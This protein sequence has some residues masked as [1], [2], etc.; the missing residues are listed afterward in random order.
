MLTS[1]REAYEQ[2]RSVLETIA[3]KTDSGPCV[4]YVGSDGA[5]HFV[6][7]VR[8]GRARFHKTI[9]SR[10]EKSKRYAPLDLLY[11]HVPE[12]ASHE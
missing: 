3:A 9:Y 7:M 12:P 10:E 5:G 8:F 6:K 2:V 1:S 4:T 11:S